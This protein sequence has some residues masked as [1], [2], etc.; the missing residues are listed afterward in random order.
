MSEQQSNNVES[1]S[2]W[3]GRSSSKGSSSYLPP[4]VM[5]FGENQKRIIRIFDKAE[6]ISVWRH[7]PCRTAEGRF[8]KAY[9]RGDFDNIVDKC[10]LCLFNKTEKYRDLKGKDMPFPKSSEYVKAVW[11]YEDNK[12]M[13]LVGNDVWRRIDAILATNVDIFSYDITVSRIDEKDKPTTYGASILPDRKEFSKVIDP[14]TI[15]SV[16]TYIDWLKDNLTKVH[17]TIPASLATKE[18][19]KTVQVPANEVTPKMVG[20]P[21]GKRSEMKAKFGAL[22]SEGWNSSLIEKLMGEINGRRKMIT[23]SAPAANDLDSLND[24]EYESFV[25][26]YEAGRKK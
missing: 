18:E 25:N 12:P 20:A 3:L 4:Y 19:V 8:L 10:P 16:E 14:A 26:M 24:E 15:P 13:L 23:A 1:G 7:V 2:G 22:L 9:C 21:S 5:G 6:P 11:S 17:V